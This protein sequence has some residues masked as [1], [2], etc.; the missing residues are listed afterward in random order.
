[1]LASFVDQENT[2]NSVHLGALSEQPD[3]M[4]QMDGCWSRN[5][6]VAAKESRKKLTHYFFTC[7][8]VAWQDRVLGVICQ[9]PLSEE[10]MRPV[11]FKL[12]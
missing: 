3:Q 7:G 8:A 5:P 4:Q 10:V 2:D 12:Y 1:M 11:L 9:K 6:T